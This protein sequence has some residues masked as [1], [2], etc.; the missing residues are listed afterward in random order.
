[1]DQLIDEI[2]RTVLSL[3]VVLLAPLVLGVVY[4]LF[5]RVGLEVSAE[6]QA[7]LEK[8]LRDLLIET[9]EYF[10]A[11]IK[12]K[13]PDITGATKLQ[14][15]IEIAVDRIPGIT[16]QEAAAYAQQLLPQIGLGAVIALRNLRQA[17]T[18]NRQVM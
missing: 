6:Q 17:A 13:I 15:F 18:G 7:K 11:R 8:Q 12:A 10:A 4:R 16:A 5:Q 2:V 3:A 14:H 1:M 9:E